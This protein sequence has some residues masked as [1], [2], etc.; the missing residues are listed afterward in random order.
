MF[1]CVHLKPELS[2]QI[3]RYPKA[4]TPED[5]SLLSPLLLHDLTHPTGEYPLFGYYVLQTLVRWDVWS[6]NKV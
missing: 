2:T 6:F 4:A 1:R 3:M 5:G